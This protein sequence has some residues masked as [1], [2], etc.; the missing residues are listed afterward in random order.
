MR[1]VW[2]GATTLLAIF[3][4]CTDGTVASTIPAL[5]LTP[6]IRIGSDTS[7]T[8]DTSD[9]SDS[10]GPEYQFTS[11]FS[12]VARGDNVY[13]MQRD[14]REIRVFGSDGR[15][16]KTIGREGAGPGE[17]RSMWSMGIVGDS[18][19]LI[20]IDL[21]RLTFFTPD[22]AL[23]STVPFD[24]VPPT[25]GQ[26]GTLFLPYADLVLRGGGYLGFGRGM[27]RSVDMGDITANPLLRMDAKGRAVDT[28]AWVS[29]RNEDMILRSAR[30]RSYRMQPFTDAPLT[31]YSP[32][33]A[34]AYVIERWAAAKPEDAAIRV[35]ALEASGDTAWVSD[36]PYVPTR[37]DPQRVDSVRASFERVLAARYPKEEITRA[38]YAP[39]YRT[40]I[41]AA[42]A[43]EDGS[44]WIRWDELTRPASFTIVGPG[45]DIRAVVSAPP[46]VRLKWASDS[47]AWGEELDE[48]DV[49]TL[50]RYRIARRIGR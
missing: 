45:G 20:D 27:A 1:R 47:L 49:P 9:S 6:E 22:G 28:L 42:V 21:R 2:I 31:V 17:F 25:L 26:D 32:A 4:S 3:A 8:S 23:I 40:P 41:T 19:W 39:A 44:L 29:I 14:V 12:V 16:R 11:I 13:V 30:S 18:L 15:Y 37:L 7:D 33:L 50:V 48:N 5:E 35:T 38:L 43:S 36:I 34:R 10:S 24:P 46:A